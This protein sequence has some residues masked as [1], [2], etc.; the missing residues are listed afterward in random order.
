[1]EIDLQTLSRKELSK[2][3]TDVEKALVSAEDRERREALKA[4][5]QAAAEYGFSLDDLSDSQKASGSKRGK[6]VPKYR[7]PANP[8][9]TWSGL[10]RKPHW[11][12]EA[13]ASGADITDLEI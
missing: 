9:Q 7:N 8:E 12:H 11:V 5:Q 2:L 6:A 3:K 1:M 13:L 4:A 10:G